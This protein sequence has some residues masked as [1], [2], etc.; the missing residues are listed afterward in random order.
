[1]NTVSKRIATVVMMALMV[2]GAVM[3]KKDLIDPP[4]VRVL[5]GVITIDYTKAI[6]SAEVTDQGGGEVKSRGIVYGKSGGKQDTVFCGSGMGVF[7][8]EL[9]GLESNTQY[10]YEAFARNAGGVGLSD[11]VS[12][13]TLDLNLP[14]VTTVSI[15]SVAISTAFCRGKVTEE[16]GSHV[17]KRGF[18]WSQSHTPTLNDY[19]VEDKGEGV[20]EFCCQITGL[21]ANTLYYVRAYATNSKGT[22]YG[23]ELELPTQNANAPI[24]TIKEES[25]G[26][27]TIKVKVEVTD[28]GG[29]P[30]IKRGICWS[31]SSTEPTAA[32][33]LVLSA[34]TTSVFFLEMD[35]L[36]PG[37]I[38]YVRAYAK[39][40]AGVVGYGESALTVKTDA[41]KPTLKTEIVSHTNN[42]IKVKGKVTNTGGAPVSERGVCWGTA[43]NPTIEGLHKQSAET[44]SSFTVTIDEGIQPGTVYHVRAYAK[45]EAGV[46]YG[47]SVADTTVTSLSVT[48]TAEPYIIPRGGQST[49]KAT[50][51]GGTGSYAYS[52]NHTSTLEGATTDH[53]IASPTATMTY[54]CTVASGGQ[55]ATDTVTVTVVNKP[56]GFQAVANG[57]NVSLSW[58]A[59]DPADSYNV[60]RD[61][62]FLKNT[63]SV[64]CYDENLN[65]ATY[66]YQVSTVYKGV[67][68][69]KTDPKDVTVYSTLGVIATADHYVIALGGNTTLRANVTGGSGHPTFS[70]DH[71]STL[72]HDNVQNPK[73]TPT[74]TTSYKVTVHDDGQTAFDTVRVSVVKAPTNLQAVASGNSVQLTW[75]AANPAQSYK[76]YRGNTLIASNITSTSYTD[77]NLSPGTYTY[78]VSTVYQGVESPKSGGA[79]AEVVSSVT[80]TVSANPPAIPEGGS[81]ILT[82]TPNGGS[83]SRSYQWN[84]SSSLNNA[85][86]QSPTATPNTTTTYTVHVTDGIGQTADG[87]VEVKVVKAPTNLQ[88]EKQGHNVHLTWNPADPATSYKVYRNNVLVAQDITNP[89]WDDNNLSVG[90]YYYKVKTVFQDVESLF[91]NTVPITIEPAPLGAIDGL[92]SVSDNQQV[93]FS[94]G[95]LQYKASTN[96]WRFATNQWSIVGQDNQNISQNYHGWTDLFG[97]G[98]SGYNHGAVCYQPWSTSQTSSDYYAYG[99]YTYNLYDQTGQADWGYNAISNGGNQ[100]NQWRTLTHG[101]W[102]YVFNDRPNATNK[103]GSATVNG[104]HG[105]VLLPDNWTT[106]SGCS[107]AS[108]MDGYTLNT[109]NSVIW[110]SMESAGAVFLP[111]AGDRIGTSVYNVGSN[112]RYWSLS[113]DTSWDSSGRAWSVY[114]IDSGLGTDANSSRYVGLSVRL[115]RS[116][117]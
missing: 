36:T 113:Y 23:G 14:K 64:S 55:T 29:S 39:N 51:A 17:V 72:N 107:F 76:V 34:D 73:A 61:G 54:T 38:Y 60:Y 109:Y 11:K 110:E 82:A 30:V 74:S 65:P 59:S 43:P 93:W 31:H 24:L 27:T 86:I 98:T 102:Q 71:S 105:V 69:P 18:C 89:S 32:N 83:G 95:N 2:F 91:S 7:S 84:P 90:T 103:F 49:L 79:P 117:Q 81:S 8:T 6:V 35:S 10:T 45:N 100:T 58:K 88:A 19:H 42:T 52:W 50:I 78:K 67:E 28:D 70:W 96:T 106:P 112:G 12:F 80:V 16:G 33:H 111:A 77:N 41:E 116:S 3:C 85:T 68:S 92:F 62:S 13:T 53:P 9:K 75:S 4:T 48:A 94:Q 15:D 87:Q 1:M 57:N 47:P 22:G 26:T 21:E 99:S 63:T 25:H 104:V 97:W 37:T 20:G 46:G 44:T 40:K 114:F 66:S 56:L 108:G 115:V 101:E 5:E